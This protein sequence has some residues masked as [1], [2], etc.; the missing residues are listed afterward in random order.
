[1]HCCDRAGTSFTRWGRR[2]LK[3]PFKALACAFALAAIPCAAQVA[4]PP[5]AAAIE[6]AQLALAQEVI[7]I[8]FPR[9]M[10]REMMMS[11]AESSMEQARAA[12]LSAAGDTFDAELTRI[13]D[14]FVERA[15]GISERSIDEATPAIFDAFARAYARQFTHDELVQIRDFVATPAGSKFVRRSSEIL[16]DPDVARANTAYMA[17]VFAALRPLQEEMFEDVLEHLRSRERT[18]AAAP[19]SGT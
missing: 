17:T 10:R 15:R 16:N 11:A 3:L 13:F 7:D 14:R 6:P 12:V 2:K 19:A 8:A 4:P 18:P 1:L 9:D 5:A